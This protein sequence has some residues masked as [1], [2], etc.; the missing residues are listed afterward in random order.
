MKKFSETVPLVWPGSFSR[1]ALLAIL[2][3]VCGSLFL[4][5]NGAGPPAT[6]IASVQ[7]TDEAIRAIVVLPYPAGNGPLA[8]YTEHL[9]WIPNIGKTSRP[10]DADSNAW[11]SREAIG[12][13]LSGPS[14]D[15]T[16]VLTRLKGVF[17]PIDLPQAVAETER[18]VILR[19]YDWRLAGNPDARIAEKMEAFLYEGNVIAAS[20]IGTPDQIAS[21]T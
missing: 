2:A 18:D 21:Q 5:A 19:E 4:I 1:A 13:W 20:V 3:I 11:T 6:S 15:L 7:T 16:E 12:Y 17:D 8:H 14:D 10:E 9:A